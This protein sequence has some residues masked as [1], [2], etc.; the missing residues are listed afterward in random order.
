MNGTVGTTHN[1][2]PLTS[3]TSDGK[4]KP[5]LQRLPSILGGRGTSGGLALPW[6]TKIPALQPPGGDGVEE[7]ASVM[8]TPKQQ[9]L[10][11][12]QI[13]SPS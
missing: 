11:E 3:K 10:V 7:V 2:Q 12:E 9:D 4:S 13:I 1:S 5:L 6:A 8:K